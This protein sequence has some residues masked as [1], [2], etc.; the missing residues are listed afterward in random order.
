MS[1]AEELLDRG[2]ITAEQFAEAMTL[3]KSE[4]LRVD[5]ALV[6]L[7]CLS[8]DA[9]LRIMSEQLSIPMV[10]LSKVSVDV[11]I[12]KNL[13]A[14]LVYRKR[15]VP[16]SQ[17]NG[18]LTVATSDPFDLYAFDELRLLTGLEIRP[19]LASEDDISKI[20]KANYGVGGDTIDEMMMSTDDLEVI[21][22]S[23][24]DTEDL[25]EMAQEASVIKLVNEIFLEALN[26]RASDIHIEPYEKDLKIRY[27]IDGVL[28]DA[29]VPPQ[30][31]RFQAAII[32]RIKIMASLNIAE[33]RLPQDGRIKLQAG[34][35]QID[36][37]VSVIP[38]LFGEGIVMRLLDKA[39]VLFTLPQLGMDETTFG[40][41]KELIDR[42]HGII[43]VTGPTG[44]GKTTTLY[45]ALQ[46]IVSPE[47]KVLT[48]EDPVEYN[49]EGVNQIQVHPKI[50]MTFAAG[51]R[52]ILRHDPD[53]VMIGEIRDSET[54][55]AAIQA[56]LTGHLVLSTL[57]TNDACSAATR[58]L[59]MGIE[60]FLVSSTLMAAMAQR[61]V[62]TICSECK[63]AYKADRE[64]LPADFTPPDDLKLYR[65]AGCRKCRGTGYHGRTGV[66]EMMLVN[67]PIRQLIMA[68]RTAGEIVREARKIGLRL[69]RED[70]WDKVRHGI[71]TPEEVTR[72]TSFA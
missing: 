35:R 26:E 9:L 1:I 49:L 55:E 23:N 30:I 24:G 2:M 42:P 33:K 54:A 51:L 5:R 38:M 57:H 27:R 39:N 70:G 58:L 3:H 29:S 63:E 47:I 59:D 44:S 18:S 20:I 12:L 45:A 13:P 41:F 10:D 48:V 60:P 46:A 4:G 64:N 71:T 25:L 37:R 7:G 8:E 69:L 66:Y 62:R 52:A 19:V 61:L 53:V 16:V 21:K 68:R 40:T 14:K 31:R 72:N 32:S 34:G 22:D 43:L 65:G 36:I 67:E 6:K 50:N 17:H 15:L 56:S 11:E 28:H